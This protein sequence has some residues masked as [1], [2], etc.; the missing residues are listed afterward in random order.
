MVRYKYPTRMEFKFDIQKTLVY[1]KIVTS[2]TLALNSY[3]KLHLI[4]YAEGPQHIYLI[5]LYAHNYCT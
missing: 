2:I 3:E 1:L 4:Y 5:I